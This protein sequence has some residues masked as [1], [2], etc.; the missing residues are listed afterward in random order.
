[1]RTKY[2]EFVSHRAYITE[3]VSDR[4]R[5]YIGI[6]VLYLA[7]NLQ[8]QLIFKPCS[9]YNSCIHEQIF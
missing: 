2:S 3:L 7:N 5:A 8:K 9:K 6:V 4:D 1:M